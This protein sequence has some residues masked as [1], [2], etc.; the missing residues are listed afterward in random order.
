MIAQVLR[1]ALGQVQI[2]QATRIAVLMFDF[3]RLVAFL[4]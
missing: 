1:P 3:S 2:H 4:V